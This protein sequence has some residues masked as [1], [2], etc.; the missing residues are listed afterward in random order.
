MPLNNT[1]GSNYGQLEKRI[2]ALLA[3]GSTYS[4]QE[5]QTRLSK[6]GTDYSVQAVY[7]IFRKLRRQ[8][9][10][11]KVRDRFSLSLTWA[12][13]LLHLARQIESNLLQS[14]PANQV[15][16]A[17]MHGLSWSFAS[18]M[19][20]DD[21]WV[22]LMLIV[23]ERSSEAQ[24]YN[25]CPHPWFYYAQQGKLEKFYRVLTQRQ[26]RIYLL[27][28]GRSYLDHEF[29]RAVSK[30][31]YNCVH[32]SG[33]TIGGTT[34]QH[35]MVIGDYVITVRLSKKMGAAIDEAFQ[36]INSKDLSSLLLLQQVISR[37]TRAR[38]SVAHNPAK[39]GT[40]RRKFQNLFGAQ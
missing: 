1:T 12:L 13:D 10:V 32:A 19:A 22:Q 7:H 23:F 29:S 21:F 30:C 24:M 20:L 9:V 35:V 8:G 28:G 33:R 17:P 11:L 3:D 16:P 37:P 39:A 38:L 18:L 15:I 26:S 36:A 14:V 27:I 31:L 6:I 2:L 4:A 34:C 5:I 25:F 40:L